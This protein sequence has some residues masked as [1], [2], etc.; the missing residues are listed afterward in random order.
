MVEGT[1]TALALSA[2]IGCKENVLGPAATIV[3][4][5]TTVRE[6]YVFYDKLILHEPIGAYGD[7]L[8]WVGV[9]GDVT[10]VGEKPIVGLKPRL[11]VYFDWDSYKAEKPDR[12]ATGAIG[13]DLYFYEDGI[14]HRQDTLKVGERAMFFVAV[15]FPQSVTLFNTYWKMGFIID[16]QFASVDRGLVSGGSG[17]PD[18]NDALS[19]A[20]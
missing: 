9:L 15:S 19:Q 10:N 13:R 3:S 5:T 8:Y 12:E 18:L 20:R 4:Q 2:L 16:G 1:L 11:L 6:K 17:S 14:L 7:T